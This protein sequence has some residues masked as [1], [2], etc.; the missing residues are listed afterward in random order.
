VATGK[1]IYHL[2]GHTD[3]VLTV[4]FNPEGTRLASA[5]PTTSASGPNEQGGEIKIWDLTSGAEWTT[6]ATNHLGIINVAFSPDGRRLAGGGQAHKVVVW[7]LVTGQESLVLQGHH[8]D[9]YALAFSP[10]GRR[11]ASGGGKWNL[12]QGDQIKIWDLA[13]G[14]EVL[15]FKA[16]PAATWGLC[17]SPD[18]QRLA[19]CAGKW[20]KDDGGEVKVWDLS[21][22]WKIK[23]MPPSP[24]SAQ[25]LDAL[26]AD[27]AGSDPQRAYR[28]VWAFI[29]APQQAL[30]YLLKHV[31]RPMGGLD[32]DRITHL[33]RKL[34]D[35]DF[36]VREKAA[37]DLATLGSA[38]HPALR[39]ALTSS[40]LEV[41]RRAAML[42][43]KK[44][45]APPLAPEELQALR[46][47][48][49]LLHFDVAE[50]RPILEVLTQGPASL[51]TAE[52]AAA[53]ER[54]NRRLARK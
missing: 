27:L 6:L 47:I 53:L 46:V 11:L 2:T 32:L 44:G 34:D 12:D 43:E 30:P 48:E 36:A 33:I 20:S 26:W 25:E 22:A 8:H 5:N 16:H 24:P 29:N 51:V 52:A 15:D 28:A 39:K 54:V 9:V 17:F 13:L 37:A 21:Q 35:N 14:R 19:T 23:P 42:L 1:E 4:A 31:H 3:R 38:A 18:G 50:V 49:V 7:E 10:D 45:A 41:R 40:S